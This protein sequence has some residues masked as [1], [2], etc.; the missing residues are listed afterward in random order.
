MQQKNFL[1][2]IAGIA[3]LAGLLFGFDTGVISGA[4][5][6]I[7][8]DFQLT[9]SM[10]EYV[11]SSVLGGA[12]LGSLFGGKV[13]DLFGRKKILVLSAICFVLGS[14]VSALSQGAFEL[15]LSRFILGLSIGIASFAAPLYLAE[16]S[17]P[18][19][20]GKIVSLNQLAITVGILGSYIVDYALAEQEAWRWML[21]L[22]IFPA[23]A[24]LVGL[25][26][27]P[28]SPRWSLMRGDSE[29]ARKTLQTI[30]QADQVEGEMQEIASSFK[31][32]SLGL[33]SLF[34]GWVLPVSLIAIG[35]SFFQ[36]AT[37]INTIIYYAPTILKQAGF[38]Q[39]KMAILATLVLGVVNVAATIASLFLIDRW[40]RRPL[41]L[42]GIIGMSISLSVM[43][44]AFY[45]KEV[46]WVST[47]AVGGMI[48]YIICFAISLGPICWLVISEIFPAELR[49]V[50]ASFATSANWMFNGVVAATFL[51]LVNRFGASG[52]FWLYATV[53]LIALVFIYFFVPETKGKTLEEIQTE[54]AQLGVGTHSITDDR[55]LLNDV[56]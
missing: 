7:K 34:S 3:A 2:L 28:E 55:S 12:F 10:T 20:R 44:L 21:G 9:D 43:G 8:K 40:G 19:M 35:L 23:I 31:L 13:I 25:R 49:G 36:Q 52:T 14:T 41:L 1:Y 47:L 33:S 15:I 5:L 45:W 29:T 54:M 24:L 56:T 39:E 37:G 22:G 18:E 16:I 53:C 11:V 42:V 27:L 30:R 32:K 46:A 17:P 51:T 4:I 50:G 26:F 6:F 48:A 38:E